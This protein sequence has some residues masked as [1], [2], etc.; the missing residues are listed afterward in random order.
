MK[1]STFAL[2]FVGFCIF[3]ICNADWI[4]KLYEKLI[5]D[6]LGSDYEEVAPFVSSGEYT[7]TENFIQSF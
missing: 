7:E 1:T 2:S 3:Y 4:D 5:E 6:Y